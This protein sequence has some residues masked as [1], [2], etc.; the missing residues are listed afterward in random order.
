M[1]LS[2]IPWPLE[3]FCLEVLKHQCALES[4][5]EFANTQIVDPTPR[6]SDS[7]ELE[8]DLKICISNFPGDADTTH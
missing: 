2:N 6:V 8:G 4:S 3:L 7:G 1:I 5:G